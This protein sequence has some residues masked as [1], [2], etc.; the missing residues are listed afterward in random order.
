MKVRQII[1]NN[2]KDPIKFNNKNPNYKISPQGLKIT[3]FIKVFPYKPIYKKFLERVK[4]S[5]LWA[6]FAPH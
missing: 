5:P 4:K 1:V 6:Y 2:W 3:P